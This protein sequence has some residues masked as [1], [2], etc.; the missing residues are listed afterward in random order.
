MC[1][2]RRFAVFLIVMPVLFPCALF[3]LSSVPWMHI[4]RTLRVEPSEASQRKCYRC[5]L[6]IIEWAK[7]IEPI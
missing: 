3:L 5:I 6:L 2:P 1:S 7:R 4:W